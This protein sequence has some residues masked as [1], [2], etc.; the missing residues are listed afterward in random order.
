MI[1]L[2]EIET[3]RYGICETS[4]VDEIITLLAD[5]FPRMDPPA[6]AMGLTAPE[7]ATFVR[8]FASRAIEENTTI[9]AR[10]MD[11]GEIAGA[12]LT[13]DSGSPM[14]DGMER[15][16]KKFDPIF[17]I[18][19]EL[20]VEYRAGRSI[21]MGDCLHLFLLG[22]AS[23]YGGHGVAQNLVTTCLHNGAK[24]GYRRAVTEAT[25]SVSQHIFGKLEFKNRVQRTYR[26]YMFEGKTP[27]A[28]IQGH[29][30]PVLMERDI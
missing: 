16:S 23:N 25:N 28:G 30:G 4:D 11:T 9:I 12:L 6:V 2:K 13:E 14:P 24:R 20:E 21:P 15:L 1:V 19:G 26:D 17:G 18:L 22:V 27:F 10:S 29:L 8:L 7:F 3:I 5:V